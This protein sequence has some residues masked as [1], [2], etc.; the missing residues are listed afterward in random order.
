MI[1]TDKIFIDKHPATKEILD[2]LN[3]ARSFCSFIESLHFDSTLSFLSGTQTHLLVLYSTGKNLPCFDIKNEIENEPELSATAFNKILGF[4]AERIPY[5][6]YWHVFDPTNDSDTEA[7][8]GDL[9]DD[10][11]DIYKDIKRCILLFDAYK[12]ANVENALYRFK[13]YF[14][15]HW[16]DHCVNALYAIHYFLQK[17]E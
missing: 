8:C 11:G 6:F 17:Q 5:R 12:T 7:V 3:A 13:F 1:P 4:I 15:H 2:F 16:G 14:E 10:L 9:L